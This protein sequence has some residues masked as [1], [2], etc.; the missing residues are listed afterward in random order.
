MAHGPDPACTATSSDPT[1]AGSGFGVDPHTTCREYWTSPMYRA[2][3][4]C[5]M[6][7][8]LHDS[9]C[10]SS[11]GPFTGPV[12]PLLHATSSACSV[13]SGWCGT[14]SHA[15]PAPASLGQVPCAIR[16]PDWPEQAL[17]SVCWGMGKGGN[18]G[19]DPAHMVSTQVQPMGP[20]EFDTS[21]RDISSCLWIL[22]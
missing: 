19:P 14:T 13:H 7:Y 1:V 4:I 8:L 15:E 5:F 18:H 6:Q 16:V 3:D 12:W 22:K 10:M 9:C 11:G 17:D 2:W 21:A 20:D